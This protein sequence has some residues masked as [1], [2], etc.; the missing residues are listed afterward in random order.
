MDFSDFE[1]KFFV[2]F[3]FLNLEVNINRF[4][5]QVCERQSK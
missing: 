1:S 3:F 4:K 5:N 2:F